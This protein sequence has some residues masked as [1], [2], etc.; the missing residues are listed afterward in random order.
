MRWCWLLAVGCVLCFAPAEA[1][2]RAWK[3]TFRPSAGEAAELRTI[4]GQVLVEAADGGILLLGRDG[5]LWNITP[6]QQV[7]REPA[8]RDFAPFSAEETAA[9]LTSEFGDGFEIVQTEHYIICS[10]AG[11]RYGEWCGMLFERLL[12]GFQSHWKSRGLEL[13][14]PRLPLAAIV[15]ATAEEFREF[16]ARDAGPAAAGAEGYYSLRTNRMVLYDLTS[17]ARGPAAESAAEITRR[18]VRS[19]ANIATVVHEATHQIAFNC[20]MH[21]RYA[22]N[23][24]WLTEGMAMYFETPDLQSSTGWRTIGRT[25]P[26]RLRQFRDYVRTRRGANSL[27]S[28]IASDE[29]FTDVSTA[30]DAY[31]EAWALSYFLIRTRREEYVRY[32]ESISKKPRLIF[33]GAEGRLR[34]FRAAFGEDLEQLDKSFLR[35]AAGLK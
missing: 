34:E 21:T 2:G 25:N 18:I 16:A 28:L 5:M 31:A 19:P 13:S 9:A 1:G 35:Y 22:D 15:F 33:D 17:G 14:A 11:R 27:E 12:S 20:G 10:G 29:R 6:K 8:G 26:G 23:P 4:E 7:E 30:A 32:L 3:V 24:L